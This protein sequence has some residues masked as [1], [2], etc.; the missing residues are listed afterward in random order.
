MAIAATTYITL[1]RVNGCGFSKTTLSSS[2]RRAKSIT[3]ATETHGKG[4]VFIADEEG[5]SSKRT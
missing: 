2:K 5:R 1:K 3:L 4:E